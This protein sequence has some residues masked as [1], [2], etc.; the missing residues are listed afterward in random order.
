MALRSD[1]DRWGTVTRIL[2]W[3]TALAVLG[4]L[5]VG[6]WMEGLPNSPDKIAIYKLHKSVGLTVLALAV[7]RIAWRLFER[8]RPRPPSMP[9]WQRA[10]A[11]TTH[12]ALYAGILVMPLSGWLYNSAS[13]FPLKWFE[14]FKV[15]ALSGADATLKAIAGEVHGTAAIVVAVAAGLHVLGALKH[16]FVDRDHVLAAMLPFHRGA[17][18][19]PAP[20]PPQTTSPET[21]P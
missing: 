16:H 1:T 7:V 18:P 3:L 19:A 2:H 4:L 9:G 8:A 10:F 14:L 13:G 21:T 11:A 17:A 15:P 12:W 20:A 5:G 6:W